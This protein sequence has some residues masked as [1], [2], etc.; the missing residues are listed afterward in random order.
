MP[1]PKHPDSKNIKDAHPLLQ[2]AWP[3]ILEA[4]EKEHPTLTLWLTCTHRTPEM[5]FELYKK[6]RQNQ[7]TLDKPKWVI[8][9][10]GHVVTNCDGITHQS[11]HSMYPAEAIDVVV[12]NIHTKR[13]LWEDVHYGALGPICEKLKLEWGGNW[14]MIRDY[15]HIQLGKVNASSKHMSGYFGP[16]DIEPDSEEELPPAPDL[17]DYPML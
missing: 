9:Q 7:G 15:P 11:K 16:N 4:F 5:Q 1:A 17:P 13:L 2:A 3:R 8:V 14:K 6:G 10:P 12:V